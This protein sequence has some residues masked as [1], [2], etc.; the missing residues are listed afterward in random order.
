M[1]WITNP[2]TNNHTPDSSLH[3]QTRVRIH[4]FVEMPRPVTLHNHGT[5]EDL[6][7]RHDGDLFDIAQY[8]L[9]KD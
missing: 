5:I 8:Q 7:W 9:M 2:G 4:L 1:T 6:N 3:P